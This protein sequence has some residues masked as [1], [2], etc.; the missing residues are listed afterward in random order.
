MNII[1]WNCREFGNPWTVQDLGLMVKEK[2]PSL[3]FVI[4]I[5][6]CANKMVVLKMRLGMEGCLAVDSMGRSGWLCIGRMM[7]KLR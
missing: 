4:E 5:K 1:S 7:R 2:R 3:V 6:V